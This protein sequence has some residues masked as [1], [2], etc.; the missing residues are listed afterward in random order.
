MVKFLLMNV[1]LLLSS[2]T[3]T[4]LWN[5][6]RKRRTPLYANQQC[7]YISTFHRCVIYISFF[8]S[9][10]GKLFISRNAALFYLKPGKRLIRNRHP[11]I[12]IQ[13]F[14]CFV[15]K[16]G[17]ICTAL[18]LAWLILIL[19]KKIGSIYSSALRKII[20]FCMNL[21]FIELLQHKI[22]RWKCYNSNIK[23]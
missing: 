8:I 4:F 1:M 2:D 10:K 6:F 14:H 18:Q 5:V 23:P 19:H 15:T 9:S 3:P 12:Y 20:G 16:G 11:T 22:W 21:D 17:F 7:L 13:L